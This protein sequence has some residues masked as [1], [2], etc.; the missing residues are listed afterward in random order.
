MTD[1][2][3][4]EPPARPRG[5]PRLLAGLG[6]ATISSS[7]VLVVLAGSS[8][9][10]TAFYRSALALPLLAVL[11]AIERRRLGKRAAAQRALAVL[12]GVFLAVDLILW[13]PPIYDLGAGVATGPRTL[14][15]AVVAP[16]PRG[17]SPQRP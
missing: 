12:A 11:A 2:A 14:P 5:Q 9:V 6:A 8:P 15:G 4:A 3:R 17:G 1:M 13:T 10:S 16:Q 7:A